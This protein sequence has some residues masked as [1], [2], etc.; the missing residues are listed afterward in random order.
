MRLAD[1]T[2]RDA[3]GKK[4]QS[5]F[6]IQLISL[7]FATICMVTSTMAWIGLTTQNDINRMNMNVD[8]DRFFVEKA[9]YKYDAKNQTVLYYEGLSDVKFNQYDL[10]F[11]S[12][13]RY[14]PIVATLLLTGDDLKDEGTIY[15]TI[16]RDSSINPFVVDGNGK[17]HL[18]N[19]FSS[20]MRVTALVGSEYYSSNENLLY[21][22]VDNSYYSAVRLYTGN[23]AGSSPS[24][25]FTTASISTINDVEVL[26]NASKTDIEI[27]I[28]YDSGD[29]VTIEGISTLIVYLYLTYDEGYNES[30]K[31]YDGL[32]GMYQRTSEALGI[33]SGDIADQSI[34]FEND[35]VSIKV[36]HS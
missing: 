9:Y 17:K 28:D 16:Q 7:V 21:S 27:S 19:T 20:I 5:S 15:V 1:K 34:E 33:T 8:Y 35:L 11:R 12:R 23:V 3:A 29:F 14:T 13:N 4:R 6:V 25:V 36:A 26:D 31:K 10:V 22:S 30:T 2:K 32:V 18:T 24:K